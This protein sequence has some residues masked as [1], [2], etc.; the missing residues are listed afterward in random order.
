MGGLDK[1][2]VFEDKSN[3]V[4]FIDPESGQVWSKTIKIKP[5][6]LVVNI[7]S[8]SKSKGEFRKKEL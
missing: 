4:K 6:K 2:A 3:V 8:M 7:S 5:K 1:L